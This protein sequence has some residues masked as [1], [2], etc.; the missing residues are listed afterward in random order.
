MTEISFEYLSNIDFEL[1][2]QQVLERHGDVVLNRDFELERLLLEKPIT[3][4][5]FTL[6]KKFR[7]EYFR[8]LE[9]GGAQ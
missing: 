5:R 1:L 2:K 9:Q 7:G 8:R 3:D 6:L 4:Y